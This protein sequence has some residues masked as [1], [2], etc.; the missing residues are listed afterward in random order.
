MT[1][2]IYSSLQTRGKKPF[3]Y[4]SPHLERETVSSNPSTR[5]ELK[6][7]PIKH[8]ITTNVRFA[9]FLFFGRYACRCDVSRLFTY[10]SSRLFTYFSLFGSN[11][12][13]RLRSP[14]RNKR[15][16]RIGYR[17]TRYLPT[18]VGNVAKTYERRRK[19]HERK[20]RMVEK[21]DDAFLYGSLARPSGEN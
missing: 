5:R 21:N 17:I 18:Q 15:V 4:G 16:E 9:I 7:S 11:V 6:I 2:V 12:E 1:L 10:F 3:Y 8:V 20:S 14:R 19:S 13:W